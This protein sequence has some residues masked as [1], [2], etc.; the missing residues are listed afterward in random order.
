M[1]E[2]LDPKVRERF[3]SKGV[4]Y[5]RNYPPK[6]SLLSEPLLMKGWQDVFGTTNKEIVE[7]ELRNSNM[8]FEWNV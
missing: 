6:K 4:M 2:E 8:S 7:K 5:I 3:E 1:Y